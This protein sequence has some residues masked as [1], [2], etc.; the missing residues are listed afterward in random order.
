MT[1]YR[2]TLRQ[3]TRKSNNLLLSVVE[4]LSDVFSD[5]T[6]NTWIPEEVEAARKRILEDFL[7]ERDAFIFR[8]EAILLDAL[9]QPCP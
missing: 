8:N 2:K 4:D 9:G 1:E 5:G 6:A 3:I 7:T